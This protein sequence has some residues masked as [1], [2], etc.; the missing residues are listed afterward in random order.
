MPI[1][2]QARWLREHL[3]HIGAS[4]VAVAFSFAQI[5][6]SALRLAGMLGVL[7]LDRP[8]PEMF[9]VALVLVFSGFMAAI[10]WSIS[11]LLPRVAT[12]LGFST[13]ARY[14]V[15]ISGQGHIVTIPSADTPQ[16][17]KGAVDALLLEKYDSQNPLSPLD[18]AKI[19]LM[20]HIA[21][22][23]NNSVTNLFIGIFI[24]AAGV[25]ILFS[26]IAQI[27]EFSDEQKHAFDATGFLSSALLPKL[28][29][30]LFVQIFSYF[31]LAMYRSNQ[32]D[33]KYFQ[34]EITYLDSMAAAMIG[35]QIN[36]KAPN[37][38]IVITALSKNE[39]NRVI[40]KNEK[41]IISS[42]EAEFIKALSILSH[43]KSVPQDV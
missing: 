14:D 7:G 12:S 17:G 34:N 18:S 40:K 21:K 28:S 35:A 9:V 10:V 37:L 1:H 32:N 41:P 11:S 4:L 15:Q 33:I 20:D 24:A 16:R 19:R 3:I 36:S 29:V 25:T 39:R 43:A 6:E 26:A 8:F 27:H 13:P 30:T 31:F 5:N 22:L 23:R 42:D 2:R 38:K